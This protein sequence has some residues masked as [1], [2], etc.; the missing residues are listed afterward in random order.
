[1][2]AFLLLGSASQACQITVHNNGDHT[3][4]NI[5]QRPS[6][7]NDWS[8]D[9]LSGTMVPGETWDSPLSQYRHYDLWIVFD[10]GKH[11]YDTNWD[12]CKNSDL[13]TNY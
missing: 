1:M 7:S 13:Y 2:G 10:D 4:V 11:T 5:Y 8:S 12:S 9:L 6:I 3:I